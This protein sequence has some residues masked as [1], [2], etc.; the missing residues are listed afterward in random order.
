MRRFVAA[1][2]F[3]TLVGGIPSPSLAQ[4]GC[5]FVRST[6]VILHGAQLGVGTIGEARQ[7][8]ER[9]GFVT[10]TDANGEHGG[11][12]VIPLREGRLEWSTDTGFPLAMLG[13]HALAPNLYG[14]VYPVCGGD[15]PPPLRPRGGDPTIGHANHAV[16]VAGVIGIV[17]DVDNAVA[18]L[19]MQFPFNEVTGRI[20]FGHSYA[21]D[22]LGAVAVD[23]RVPGGG[24]VRL[25]APRGPTARCAAWRGTGFGRWIGLV[26]ESD[27]VEA[28]ARW[29]ASHE[30]PFERANGAVTLDPETT[31]GVYLE[32]VAE[33]AQPVI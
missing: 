10:F 29:F 19:E 16:R 25:L 32:F 14:L 26:I 8:S 13:T 1:V 24:F 2:V 4:V 15:H 33:G 28:T 9:L 12:P 30:V 27:D 20:R 17:S 7:R 3:S 6:A 11:L 22:A 23:A 21:L 31:G 5:C 18:N